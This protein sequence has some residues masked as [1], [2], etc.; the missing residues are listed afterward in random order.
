MEGEMPCAWLLSQLRV[1]TE[2]ATLEFSP[3]LK[4]GALVLCRDSPTQIRGNLGESSETVRPRLHTS[5][6]EVPTWRAQ[7]MGSDCKR[8][9]VATPRSVRGTYRLQTAVTDT[10]FHGEVLCTENQTVKSA[11]W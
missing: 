10:L 7:D 3:S 9:Q 4:P 2:T 8:D 1:R 5:T 11:L 6:A